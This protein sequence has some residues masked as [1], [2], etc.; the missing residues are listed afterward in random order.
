[1]GLDQSRDVENIVFENLQINGKRILSPEEG[2]IKIG[3]YAGK[4]IFK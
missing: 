1:M 4:I 3:P 2:N